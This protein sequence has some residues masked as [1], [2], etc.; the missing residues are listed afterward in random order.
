MGTRHKLGVWLKKTAQKEKKSAIYIIIS[1][2]WSI[3]FIQ[4]T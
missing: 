4:S 1:S 3:E 2:I